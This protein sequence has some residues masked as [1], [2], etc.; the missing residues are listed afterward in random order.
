MARQRQRGA[1]LRE[2]AAAPSAPVRTAACVRPAIERAARAANQALVDAKPGADRFTNRFLDV[3]KI[4]S[5]VERMMQDA[6]DDDLE[7]LR[8]LGEICAAPQGPGSGGDA[9]VMAARF[10]TILSELTTLGARIHASNP[11]S[12]AARAAFMTFLLGQAIHDQDTEALT[13]MVDAGAAAKEAVFRKRQDRGWIGSKV[14]DMAAWA[15]H[16]EDGDK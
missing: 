10:E 6:T 13:A 2:P 15:A 14:I 11:T 7:C 16:R 3:A 9:G 5:G 4:L 1:F 12:L 8:Q